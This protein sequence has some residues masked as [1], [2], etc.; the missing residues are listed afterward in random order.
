ME[1]YLVATVACDSGL[2]V[3]AQ[4]VTNRALITMHAFADQL[5][6]AD[7]DWTDPCATDAEL[8][9]LTEGRHS[10]SIQKEQTQ[11]RERLNA[12]FRTYLARL[13]RPS[14][15]LSRSSLALWQ[16]VRLFICSSTTP[17]VGNATFV[18]IQS[19]LGGYP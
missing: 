11:T 16:A 13:A 9:W 6:V 19:T 15:C 3:R 18:R 1:V 10:I 12:K 2:I 4:V 5:P 17:I 7:Q 14:G 8:N